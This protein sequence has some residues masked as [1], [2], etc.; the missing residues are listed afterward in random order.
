M[1]KKIILAKTAGFCFGVERAVET[2][3]K[4]L[5]K[6]P[7]LIYTY[8]PIIH[9][10]NVVGE[11]K[12][13]GVQVIEEDRDLSAIPPGVAVI[14]SHGVPKKTV[15]D[16]ESRGFN[17]VDATCPFVKKIH[18]IVSEH[19]KKG[20]HILIIG[21][22]NH[23]EI[24]GIIGWIEGN[25]YSVIDSTE[26]AEAFSIPKEKPVCL[27]AQTTYNHKK[28]ENLVEIVKHKGYDVFAVST[29]CNATHERQVEAAQIASIVDVMMV[30][31]GR[32]SSNTRK[33]YEICKKICERTYFIETAS[34]ID[35]SVLK[36]ATTI[37][38]TAGAST[39]NILIEEVS[40]RC[41]K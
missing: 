21:N 11:L 29:I 30:I 4:E 35:L 12:E 14:R 5:E 16:L 40:K 17:V 15:T 28:F 8:G 37:G 32:S 3:E 7:G 36:S 33:L 41:H 22:A 18:N 6:K 24:R 9:N 20:Y 26:E 25:D 27:V 31:G 39:P 1:E 19:S 2:V 38:I 10:D 23:P 13:K 34:D